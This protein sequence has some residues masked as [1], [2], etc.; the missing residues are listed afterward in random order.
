MAT[1]SLPNIATGNK[2]DKTMVNMC[3]DI[4][5]E[6]SYIYTTFNG[7]ANFCQDEQQDAQEFLLHLLNGINDEM[8]EVCI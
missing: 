6:P 8:L 7:I 4:A 3:T 2:Y 1:A 5:F